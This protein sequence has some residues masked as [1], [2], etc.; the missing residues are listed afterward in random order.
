MFYNYVELKSELLNYGYDFQ[1]KTDT[2]VILAAYDKWGSDCVN[3]FNGMWA[4]AL[5]NK[6]KNYVFCSRD[7]F[8]IKP[9]YYAHTDERFIFGSE[10]K[11]LLEYFPRRYVNESIVIDY[12]VTGFLEHTD[13]TFFK[14][15]FKLNPACNLI[16]NLNTNEFKQ[17]RYYKINL[18]SEI[19]KK[20]VPN[21]CF[22]SDVRI[23]MD[24]MSDYSYFILILGESFCYCIICAFCEY[25]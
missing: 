10:I 8:G 14:N 24:S 1:T 7:R 11:Q 17:V 9:F 15:I 21:I 16:Y 4:F 20:D 12:L 5:Y 23:I 18:D 19:S 6:E 13:Q 2:E 3:R 22:V 25:S